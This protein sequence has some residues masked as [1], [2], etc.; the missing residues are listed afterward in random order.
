MPSLSH[1]FRQRSLG[2]SDAREPVES[3]VLD[4]A[5]RHG[6]LVDQRAP[7]AAGDDAQRIALE[8]AQRAIQALDRARLGVAAPGLDRVTRLARRVA[9][10]PVVERKAPGVLVQ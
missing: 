4:V 6:K 8:V 7:G 3:Q 9:I 10:F 5:P 1:S 2:E